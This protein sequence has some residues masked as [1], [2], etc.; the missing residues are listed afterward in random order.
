MERRSCWTV[1]AV[2]FLVL[3]IAACLFVLLAVPRLRELKAEQLLKSL[4]APP[5]QQTATALARFLDYRRVSTP[6]G[7]RILKVLLKP[8]ATARGAYAAGAVAYITAEHPFDLHFSRMTLARSATLRWNGR[9][10]Q[11][12]ASTGGNTVSRQPRL[13][14]VSCPAAPGV[15]PG[16]IRYEYALKQGGTKPGSQKLSPK[17]PTAY[18]CRFEVP[19][20]IRVVPSD[21]A[22]RIELVSNPHLDSAMERAIGVCTRLDATAYY[23]A[24][25]GRHEAKPSWT[26][27]YRSLPENVAFRV[28][29]VPADGAPLPY[30]DLEFRARA[31]TSGQFGVAHP[32]EQ[33]SPGEHKGHVVLEA[34]KDAAYPDAA[35]KRI[36]GGTLQFP[37]WF[38]VRKL[39]EEEARHR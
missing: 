27:P 33:T 25:D 6:L 22:E 8:R 26:I 21:Q 5:A 37:V 15:Y 38:R 20:T 39:T 28:V 19:F 23:P 7:N 18:S 12:S 36:W 14:T 32:P 16:A 24:N 30:K 11:G 3:V 29:F 31:G 2:G 1:A 35:I 4:E 13:W 17:D 9:D 10:G 34:H